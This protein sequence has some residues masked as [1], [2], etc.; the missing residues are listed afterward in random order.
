M[1]GWYCFYHVCI[2]SISFLSWKFMFFY[3][4]IPSWYCLKISWYLSTP[5]TSI[6]RFLGFFSIP[7]NTTLIY[8][9][10][11]PNLL[12]AK[13]LLDTF[14][15]T[16]SF[17]SWYLSIPSQS[18]EV[19]DSIYRRGSTQFHSY[20]D[21]LIYLSN[22]PHLLFLTKIPIP[23]PILAYTK[24]QFIGKCSK[25][26]HLLFSHAFHAL[27]PTFL[28]LILIFFGGFWGFWNFLQILSMGCVNLISHCHA[29]HSKYI[30]FSFSCIF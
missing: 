29:L 17:Y 21:I 5:I 15:D 6:E 13:Y 3:I 9:A 27:R 7:L 12:F 18:I 10:N 30:Y 14:L 8:R 1:Y 24:L 28:I 23:I 4:S 16:L 22:W 20:S 19:T 2:F 11:F 26:H 25:T